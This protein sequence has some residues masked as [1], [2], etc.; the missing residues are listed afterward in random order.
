M[1]TSRPAA[2][3]LKLAGKSATTSD[4]VRLGD[5][6]GLGVVLL[7]RLVLVAQ[8]LLDHVLH[9]RGEVGQPLLDLAA[10][11]SRSGW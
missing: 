7:D 5:L 6:A 2:F 9:V 11:R 3:S 8:V 4:A 10:A 1:L